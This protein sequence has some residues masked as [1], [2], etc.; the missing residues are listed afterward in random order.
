M[1]SSAQKEEKGGGG[2]RRIHANPFNIR[3]P[4]AIPN[5]DLVFGSSKQPFAVDVGFGLGGFLRAM[6]CDRPQWNVLGLEI[7][8][9]WVH[10]I[11]AYAQEHKIQNLHA[12]VANANAHLPALIPDGQLGHLSLNFP[13][14]WFKKRHH[15][16]RVAKPEWLEALRSKWAP[17]AELHA[18]TDYAPVGEQIL[19]LL[20]NHPD[21]ENIYGH[22]L[23]PEA[24]V[25]WRT[26]RELSHQARGHAIY[27]MAFTYRGPLSAGTS[28]QKPTLKALKAPKASIPEHPDL[29]TT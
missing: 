2:R 11:N 28:P 23:A 27:R 6:A 3:G 1:P 7:R 14:P 9:H 13:D 4:I 15:K 24:T 17:G 10:A 25:P 5:W 29:P 26:E 20:E 21:F 16:R 8:A 12:M 18:M 22:G 19:E